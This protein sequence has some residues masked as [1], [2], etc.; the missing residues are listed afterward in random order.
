MDFT[1][2]QC[3]A[4]RRRTSATTCEAYPQRIPD[5]MLFGGG[6]HR[7]PRP[8]D[9]GKRFELAPG[10]DAAREFGYWTQVYGA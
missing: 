7:K 2:S 4:C 5:S 8:G 10:P 6:D 1:P 3:R 9:G